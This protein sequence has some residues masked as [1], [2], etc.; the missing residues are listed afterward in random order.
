[1]ARP[2]HGALVALAGGSFVLTLCGCGG[3]A[4]LAAHAC[5]SVG[6]TTAVPDV[7]GLEIEKA[8]VKLSHVGLLASTVPTGGSVS[9]PA[10]PIAPP[11]SVVSQ[12][13][14]WRDHD[15]VA[16]KVILY[17]T[18]N[19]TASSGGAYPSPPASLPDDWCGIAA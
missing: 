7:V 3:G 14:H 15:T 13:P 5:P 12:V 9:G 4:S 6:T 10:P 17:V 1:M 16:H 8:Y 11:G 2:V 19:S 18:V